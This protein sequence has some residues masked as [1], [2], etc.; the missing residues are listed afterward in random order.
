MNIVPLRFILCTH[1]QSLWVSQHYGV[2]ELK[3]HFSLVTLCYG[4]N[5]VERFISMII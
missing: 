4:R 3:M 1:V 2:L 5:D